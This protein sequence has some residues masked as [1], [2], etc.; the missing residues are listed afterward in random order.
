[1]K[2]K[3]K[4]ELKRLREHLK[5]KLQEKGSIYV[6]SE[7]VE[8]NDKPVFETFVRE[9]KEMARGNAGTTTEK[10]VEEFKNGNWYVQYTFDNKVRYSAGETKKKA[11]KQPTWFEDLYVDCFAGGLEAYRKL[12]EKGKQ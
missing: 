1:M 8:K 6:S 9:L 5:S 2:Q 11:R 10:H 3:N 12:L 7:W 4:K